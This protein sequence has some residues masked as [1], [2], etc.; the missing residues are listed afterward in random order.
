MGDKWC[1]MPWPAALTLDQAC[2]YLSIELQGFGALMD[3]SRILPV[4]LGDGQPRWRRFDLDS[5]LKRLPV[6][7][8]S[9][10]ASGTA[11]ITLD[12]KTID[13]IVSAI[14]TSLPSSDALDTPRTGGVAS[15]KGAIKQLGLSRT[16]LY[17][18]IADGTLEVRKIG[19]RTLVLQD[20]IDRLISGSDGS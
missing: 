20:S 12:R 5:L 7:P 17:K 19:K 16:T 2:R 9:T 8:Q 13:E 15:I 1:G 10:P 11:T 14:R 4:D 6:L 18:M 3:R